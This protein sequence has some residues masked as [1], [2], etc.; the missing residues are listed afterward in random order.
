MQEFSCP[1][2]S[3]LQLFLYFLSVLSNVTE[4]LKLLP[5]SEAIAPCLTHIRCSADDETLLS[6]P[7]QPNTYNVICFLPVW[8][9]YFPLPLLFALTKCLPS[10]FHYSGLIVVAIT[11]IMSTSE[12]VHDLLHLC[13]R[14][15]VC[16]PAPVRQRQQHRGAG[17]VVC[18][19]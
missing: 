3:A 13:S 7:P 14:Q 15:F 17:R 6:L 2:H 16:E 19:S 10:L 8:F 5:Y 11:E 1:P 4:Y 12:E 18:L 9:T